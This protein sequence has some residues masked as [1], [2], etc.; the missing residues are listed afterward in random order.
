MQ[1]IIIRIRSH[2]PMYMVLGYPGVKSVLDEASTEVL[3]GIKP[4]PDN[5]L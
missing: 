3:L 4:T 1:I 2:M 5:G